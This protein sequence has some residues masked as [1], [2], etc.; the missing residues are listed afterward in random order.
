M[1]ILK[2]IAEYEQDVEDEILALRLEN[3]RLRGEVS[4]WMGMA[5]SAG[6]ERSRL[7]LKAAL[8]GA[9]SGPEEIQTCEADR[10]AEDPD[11]R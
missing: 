3:Q 5:L 11:E 7:L 2:M 8:A 4:K 6:E 1:G 9:F 10:K